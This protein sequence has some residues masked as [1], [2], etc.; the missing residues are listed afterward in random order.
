MSRMPKIFSITAFCFLYAVLAGSRLAHSE[1]IEFETVSVKIQPVK[2]SKHAY[3]VRGQSGLI[4]AKNEGFNSNAGFVVTKDGVIVFDALGTPALGRAL[5]EEIRKLTSVPIKKVIVSH[6]HA[7]HFYG[8][9]AFVKNS[10]IEI[11]A[12]KEVKQYLSTQAPVARLEERKSSLFPWVNSKTKLIQPTRYIDD[13][14]SFTEGG[15]SFR[16]LHA[17]PAHTSEDLMLL[18]EEEGVLFSGDIFFAGR[19]P[20]VGDANLNSWLKAIDRLQAFSPKVLVGGHGDHSLDA[21]RDL[22]VTKEYLLF[23]KAAMRNAVDQGVDFAAA[24]KNTDWSR[25][26]AMPLF[27]EANRINAYSA[28]LQAEEE[29]LLSGH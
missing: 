12:H 14:F 9:Q 16:V 18:V 28:Y 4:S 27:D 10:D 3:Y 20:F 11:V 21:P 15:L 24:Y 17:G 6:Y 29:S 7:D 22:R 19:I 26:D 25:Y 5:L 1:E 13:D 8:L 2:V 23:L